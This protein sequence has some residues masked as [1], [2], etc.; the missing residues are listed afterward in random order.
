MSTDVDRMASHQDDPEAPFADRLLLALGIW[1]HHVAEMGEQTAIDAACI[2]RRDA[3]KFPMAAEDYGNERDQRELLEGV[4]RDLANAASRPGVHGDEC[5]FCGAGSDHTDACIWVRARL[6][7]QE[8]CDDC[9]G[10]GDCGR[11]DGDGCG[12]GDWPAGPADRGYC[13]DGTC[14][15]CKG[16]GLA[17][18]PDPE[19]DR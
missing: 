18:F 9:G 6:I 1:P 13:T 5:K 15:T 14:T 8:E 7:V 19:E 12:A 17:P 10:L 4:V 3:H 2:I 11:C 16:T